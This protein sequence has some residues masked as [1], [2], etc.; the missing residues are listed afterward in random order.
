M[1]LD[2]CLVQRAGRPVAA[3]VGLDVGR[4]AITR[5]MIHERHEAQAGLVQNGL[6]QRRDIR[7]GEL[8]AQME[9]VIDAQHGMPARLREAVEHGPE[10]GVPHIP[11][12]CRSEHERIEDGGDAGARELGIVG[13][14][15][16]DGI[17]LHAGARRVV[18]LE[19]V[20]V[21][22][23]QTR[24]QQ[25]AL[26]VKRRTHTGGAAV[27]PDDPA[28]LQGEAAGESLARQ[29]ER[30][31]RQHDLRR[32]RPLPALRW[33]QHA[34]SFRHLPRRPAARP[35]GASRPGQAEGNSRQTVPD[36]AALPLGADSAM[37]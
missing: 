25:I 36:A 23:D 14:G 31:V 11:A 3:L 15:G 35:Q 16:R 17:P 12:G 30:R 32:V 21:Q 6:E 37:G 28:A 5:R 9:A 18:P 26:E 4:L 2:R 29:H 24:D 1:R 27:D 10:V 13:H 34:T 22:L 20:G 33:L 7:M 8:A 19:I